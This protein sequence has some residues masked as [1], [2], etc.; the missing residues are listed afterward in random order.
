MHGPI[1]RRTDRRPAIAKRRKRRPAGPPPS[2]SPKRDRVATGGAPAKAARAPRR[3][4]G[5]P[6]PS[7]FR[8]VLIRAAL[9]AAVYYLFL[10][11]ALRTDPGGAALIS[12][13]G[14]LLMIPLGLLLDRVRYRMQLRRWQQARGGGAAPRRAPDAEGP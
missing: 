13:L 6:V 4:A 10:V 14:F 12:G 3:Q 7:S 5:E 11:L 1:T 9:I 8:G 2:R